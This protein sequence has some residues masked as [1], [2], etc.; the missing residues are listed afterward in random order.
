M[1]SPKGEWIR[2]KIGE[3]ASITGLTAGNIR[4]YEKEHL[5]SPQKSD[6]NGYRDYSE[7]E[8]EQLKRIKLLR[9]I[10]VPVKEIRECLETDGSLA[11]AL[12]RVITEQREKIKEANESIMMAE[13]LLDQECDLDHLP[14]ELLRSAAE[15]YSAYYSQID[16]IDEDNRQ[17][18]KKY[19]AGMIGIIVFI[20]ITVTAGLLLW[21]HFWAKPYFAYAGKAGFVTVL[22]IGVVLSGLI[23]RILWLSHK[24]NDID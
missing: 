24:E 12:E 16:M 11:G 22:V 2:M 8:V 21:V 5:I 3:A 1:I 6:A 17:R 10:G 15:G 9:M 20:L 23:I 7:A 14:E 4:F 13:Y 18:I 19:K